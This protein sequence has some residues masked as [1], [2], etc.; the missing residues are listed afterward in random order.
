[1]VLSHNELVEARLSSEEETD[2]LDWTVYARHET[3]V[4]LPGFGSV[5][6]FCR[7]GV[8]PEIMLSGSD[9]IATWL[10]AAETGIEGNIRY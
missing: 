5:G 3:S 2:P 6:L 9:E 4:V 7:I 8:K 1:M 10:F